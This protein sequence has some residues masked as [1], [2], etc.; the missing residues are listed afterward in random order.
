MFGE[1][2]NLHL[3]A[4][5]SFTQECLDEMTWISSSLTR[6][7]EA[8]L[9]KYAETSNL[10]KDSFITHVV[11]FDTS[12]AIPNL[13]PKKVDLSYKQLRVHSDRNLQAQLFEC[14]ADARGI[15]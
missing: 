13:Y 12:I 10:L 7:L 2:W 5:Y 4:P 3:L 6:D 15:S 14:C 1:N 8:K 9:W 11:L